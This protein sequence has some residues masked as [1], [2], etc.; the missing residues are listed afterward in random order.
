MK[1]HEV[2]SVRNARSASERTFFD[3]M[4]KHDITRKAYKVF[5][6]NQIDWLVERG[7]VVEDPSLGILAPTKAA[8][9]LF[10]VWRDGAI[11]TE[12]LSD[13]TTQ[14]IEDLVSRDVLAYCDGLFTPDEADLLNYLFN[15]AETTNSLGLRNRYSHADRVIDDPN[16]KT[17][18]HDYYAMLT[19]LLVITLKINDELMVHTGKGG[20]KD[21][22][23]WPLV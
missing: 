19:L 22:V 5:L 16:A 2:T 12:H 21:F 20:V 11:V 10:L 13:G 6:H 18:Q 15:D 1:Q 4:R 14:L 7:L 9:T 17:I 23:D 3:V 8:F